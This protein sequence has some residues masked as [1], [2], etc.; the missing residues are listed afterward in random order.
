MS[1]K[2]MIT[3]LP[4]G[5]VGEW[6]SKVSIVSYQTEFSSMFLSIINIERTLGPVAGPA[7]PG[8]IPRLA[9]HRAKLS[10]LASR[11]AYSSTLF[12]AVGL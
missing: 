12:T 6:S 1:D 4:A 10:S 11:L 9:F 8:T 5:R 3:V 7:A 2:L